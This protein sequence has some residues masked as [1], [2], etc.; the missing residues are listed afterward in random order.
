MNIITDVDCSTSMF[1]RICQIKFP[2][3]TPSESGGVLL[4]VCKRGAIKGTLFFGARVATADACTFRKPD[5]TGTS[6]AKSQ[7]RA[8]FP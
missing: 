6:G 7:H 4:N 8:F 1:R 2:D 3:T 5:L